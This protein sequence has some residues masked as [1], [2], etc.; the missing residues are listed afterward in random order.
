MDERTTTATKNLKVYEETGRFTK[1]LKRRLLAAIASENC[2]LFLRSGDVISANAQVN[3]FHEP[4]LA[5][6]IETY[7][8]QGY[9]DFLIDIGANIGLTS[10]QSG[11][12]FK[13]VHMFEP[14]PLCL[15]ILEVNATIALTTD[16]KVHP[17]GLG[18]KQ[19]HCVLTVPRA[20]WGGAFI[21]DESNAYDQSLLLSKDGFSAIDAANYFKV[22]VEIRMA[23]L[24]LQEVFADLRRLNLTRGVIKI[25]VEGYESVVL[26][27]IA[28]SLPTD[29][30]AVV[31]FENW[32]PKARLA[33]M[34]APF[35]RA[36][37][38]SK[39]VRRRSWGNSDPLFT[40][41][42]KSAF[43]RD[44]IYELTSEIGDDVTGEIVIELGSEGA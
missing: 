34:V 9:A 18:D 2:N 14:N 4:E 29:F 24:A 23:A 1:R 33:D 40:R 19:R 6:L 22:D 43:R 31:I 11:N 41:L 32:D 5:G 17:Y 10:C 44:V 12:L 20:N 13:Q 3:G 36:S 27:G 38:L 16:F 8:K 25:D 42:L 26:K 37:R 21:D 7:T 35:Q 15:K 28:E 30:A 39:L